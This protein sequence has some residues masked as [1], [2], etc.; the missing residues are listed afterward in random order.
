MSLNNPDTVSPCFVNSSEWLHHWA[1]NFI[2]VTQN[3]L[4][5]TFNETSNNNNSPHSGNRPLGL[6][7]YGNTPH[8]PLWTKW[9]RNVCLSP[10][11]V[12]V[13]TRSF[14]IESLQLKTAAGVS[15]KL[16][17]SEWKQVS[18]CLKL[19]LQHNPNY[20]C[21]TVVMCLFMFLPQSWSL[22]TM[23][24]CARWYFETSWSGN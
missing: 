12:W 14:R 7:C 1:V 9:P 10:L 20:S 13:L 21:Q 22:Q 2:N 5:H 19:R 11:K 6:L 24:W 18:N 4:L 8:G 15:Y 16:G 17:F 23:P 3:L